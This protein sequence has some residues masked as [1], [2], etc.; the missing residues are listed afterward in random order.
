MENHNHSLN[1][2]FSQLGLAITHKGIEELVK[3]HKPLA[4][5]IVLHQ[6]NFGVH[7]KSLFTTIKRR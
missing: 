7:H 6:A 2:L 4:S 3:K 5:D 1:N